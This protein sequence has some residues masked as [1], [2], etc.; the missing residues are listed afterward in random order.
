MTRPLLL[1][2]GIATRLE[3]LGYAMT[4]DLWSGQALLDGRDKALVAHTDFADAGADILT[5][6]TYQCSR[7]LLAKRSM[8]DDRCAQLYRDS[9]ALCRKANESGGDVRKVA[10]SVGPFGASLANG[11]EYRG[12]YGMSVKELVAFHRPA[13]RWAEQSGA[14]FL[15][16]ET[17]PDLQEV[18]ALVEL[19]REVSLP[20]WLSLS[21]QDGERL[22]DGTPLGKV[23]EA[24]QDTGFWAVGV[25]CTSAS[26]AT[27][28]V[29][30]LGR[31]A[32]PLI[33][34]PNSG[35]LYGTREW[36][37]DRQTMDPFVQ[38]WIELGVVAFGGCCRT[39]PAEVEAMR[40]IVD[41][42][43]S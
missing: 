31:A 43:G 18:C 26:T 28:A 42:A 13:M 32:L 2:G 12:G 34:Y 9:V 25:N 17:V 7:P 16:L 30:V 22:A 5:T 1:D 19:A 27:A 3:A 21:V 29:E 10:V 39:T 8:D 35:E 4:T 37:G 40:K 38:R 36:R 23:A 33:V 24:C 15:A 11:S 14:D 20:T 41:N 6:L